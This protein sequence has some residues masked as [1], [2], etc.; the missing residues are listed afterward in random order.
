MQKVSD[1]CNET[2]VCTHSCHKIDEKLLLCKWAFMV[3]YT[4]PMFFS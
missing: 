1:K 3:G 4:V 2:C